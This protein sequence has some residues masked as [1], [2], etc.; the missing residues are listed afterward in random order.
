MVNLLGWGALWV[1]GGLVA[2]VLVTR[3]IARGR[4]TDAV[5][6][7]RAAYPGKDLLITYSNSPHWQAY[8]EREWLPRWGPRAVFFNRSLPWRR[9]EPRAVLWRACTRG[10][11]HTPSAIVLHGTPSPQSIGFYSAFRDYKHGKGTALRQA[12]A[13]VGVALGERPVT[14]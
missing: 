14:E 9:D 3:A 5:R 6:R 7:F 12:E 13:R 10:S 11:E 1:G 2:S 8:I 4:R